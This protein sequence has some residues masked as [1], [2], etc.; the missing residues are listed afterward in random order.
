MDG[1]KELIERL[2]KIEANQGHQTHLLEEV[3]RESKEIY[4]RM[5]TVE[6]TAEQA[7]EKADKNERE[8]QKYE[9]EQIVARRWLI[10]T[11]IGLLALILPIFD[12]L[13]L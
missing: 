6:N 1:Q 8:L 5:S 11:V 13:V 10:G 2:A 3:R 12:K 4:S 9:K 7:L